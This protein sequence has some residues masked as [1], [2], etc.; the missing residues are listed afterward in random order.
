MQLR[1]GRQAGRLAA[2]LLAGMVELVLVRASANPTGFT[3][4]HFGLL[5][6][7]AGVW[8]AFAVAS[9]LL[10]RVR[11]RRTVVV[12][13][14][15]VGV[16]LRL[17]ALSAKAPLSDD[18]YRYAWDG[19]VQTHGIDPYRYPPL[20]PE[21]APLRTSDWLFPAAYS[22]GTRINRPEDRTIYPPVAEA[23]FTLVHLVV[24][25]SLRDRGY[26]L[27]GLVVD[28]AVLAVL[29]ALL[30]GERRRW[31]P[32]YALSPMPVIEAVQN[33]HVDGLGVLFVLLALLALRRGHG[34]WASLSLAA[35]TLVKLYPA[36]LLPALLKAAGWR[37]RLWRLAIFGGAVV[38]AYA[39]HV[40]AVGLR[41]VGYLPG[42]LQEEHYDQGGRYLLVGLTGLSGTAATAAVAVL[43]AIV[44][45]WVWRAVTSPT[46]AMLLLLAAALLLATPVQPWYALL[47]AALATVAGRPEMLAIA[48]AGYPLFFGTVLNS[49]AVGYGRT[50]YGVALLVVLGGCWLRRSSPRSGAVANSAMPSAKLT[51][52]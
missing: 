28:L 36:L 47:L 17:A 6:N 18:L 16:L 48:A 13:S 23:W 34:R 39:P 41:V 19:V 33:A 30:R 32:L 46:H 4:R 45:V 1:A 52:A 10:W 20:A 38:L 11:R 40:A 43:M 51:S 8:L 44:V 29:L 42:Y 2:A 14:L 21:L 7:L 5:A 9:W 50:S 3:H 27:A 37:E 26:E 25:L 24:P 31:L 15:L 12:V 22:N 49:H 35:A